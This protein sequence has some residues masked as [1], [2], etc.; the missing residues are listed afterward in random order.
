MRVAELQGF[1]RTL[2]GPLEASGARKDLLED[3]SRA[4][5]ALQPFAELPIKDFGSFLVRAEEY[6]RT[7]IVP[8]QAKPAR[9][10]RAAKPKTPAIALDEAHQLVASLYERCIDNDV[11]YEHISAEIQKLDKMTAS[12][13]K[14]VAKQFGVGPGKTKKASLDAILDKITRRK[15]THV[16]TQF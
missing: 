1:I 2:V 3:L 11:S 7:G 9:A 16:R 12:A 15:T 4:I 14:E 10:P 8:V 6:A 13:L 5:D